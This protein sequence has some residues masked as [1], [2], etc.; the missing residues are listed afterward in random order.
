VLGNSLKY[1]NGM[2]FT[3]KD[4]DNDRSSG[5]CAAQDKGAWWYNQCSH[6]NLNGPYATSAVTGVKTMFWYHFG[7][8]HEALRRASM[9]VR[10]W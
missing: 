1:H 3:T 5:S 8:K 10:S 4:Q 7:N 6:S 2:K 9:M